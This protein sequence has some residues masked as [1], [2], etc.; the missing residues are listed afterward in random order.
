MEY[1]VLFDGIILCL[2]DNS[3]FDS[4]LRPQAAAT[5]V[6]SVRHRYGGTA[7]LWGYG[8]NFR[9]HVQRPQIITEFEHLVISNPE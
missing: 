1:L 4:E 5:R 9:Y 3:R 2:G 6:G 8:D 7:S